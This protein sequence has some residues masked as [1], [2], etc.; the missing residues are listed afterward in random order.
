MTGLPSTGSDVPA[1]AQH[2]TAPVVQGLDIDIRAMVAA[3]AESVSNGGCGPDD[4]LYLAGDPAEDRPKLEKF[5]SRFHDAG[6]CVLPFIAFGSLP[7]PCAL[8]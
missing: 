2:Q 4:T 6:D 8:P 5:L 7:C 3:G 1:C